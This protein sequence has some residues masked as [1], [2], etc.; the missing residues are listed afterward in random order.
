M[1]LKTQSQLHGQGKVL[2]AHAMTQYRRVQV[3]LH[4]FL[5]SPLDDSKKKSH[6]L[7]KYELLK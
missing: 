2:P 5:T 4:A 6:P 3:Q 7:T 1:K